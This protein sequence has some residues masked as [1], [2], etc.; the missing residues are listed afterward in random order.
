MRRRS[1]T[2]LKSTTARLAVSGVE[3][4]HNAGLLGSAK[5]YALE[6]NVL[7]DEIIAYARAAVRE[8]SITSLEIE[9]AVTLIKEA[10][11]NAEYVTHEHTY[12]H[13]RDFW[14]PKLF[15]RDRFVPGPGSFGT[16]LNERL[17]GRA[18]TILEQH[19]PE[20]LPRDVEFEI[21]RLEK[22]WQN[23]VKA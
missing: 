13:F 8:P 19:Q 14:Y 1:A 10:G 17:N 16:D 3:M 18:R 2:G 7:A 4:V 5:L 6:G 9:E 23:R 21:E 15:Y 11:P 12:T 20:P 22:S